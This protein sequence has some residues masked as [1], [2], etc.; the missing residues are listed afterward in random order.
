MYSI[1]FIRACSDCNKTTE[2]TEHFDNELAAI[3]RFAEI[4][5]KLRW[6]H[7][8]EKAVVKVHSENKIIATATKRV[9]SYS[10]HFPNKQ[11]NKAYLVY[12][13]KH[14]QTTQLFDAYNR[15]VA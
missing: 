3:E 6:A 9:S 7:S 8:I 10:Q 4:E 15:E 14:F 11:F 2:D 1:Y 12:C 13:R 5:K